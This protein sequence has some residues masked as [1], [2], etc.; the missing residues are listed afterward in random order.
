VGQFSDELE[1][2]KQ[3][4]KIKSYGDAIL[5]AILVG[6]ALMVA[7]LSSVAIWAKVLIF[8]AAMFAI[9]ILVQLAQRRRSRA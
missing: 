2:G 5:R 3:S 1:A 8:L 4:A 6:I 9:G 7:L